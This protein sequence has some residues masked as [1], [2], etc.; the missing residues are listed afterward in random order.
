MRINE[1]SAMA[2]MFDLADYPTAPSKPPKAHGKTTTC[3]QQK[4]QSQ[5]QRNRKKYRK[6]CKS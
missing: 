3:A 5:K 4:R 2:H 6:L 1:L